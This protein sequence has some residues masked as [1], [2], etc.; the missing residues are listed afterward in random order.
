M[1][2]SKLFK[3][4]SFLLIVT[5][6][7]FLVLWLTQLFQPCYQCDTGFTFSQGGFWTLT[8]AALTDS[9]NPC[10]LA[11][12]LI[13]IE[14]LIL[15]RRSVLKIGLSF[16]GGIYLAYLLIGLG[17]FSGFELIK[18]IQ[19]FHQVIGGLAILVGILN[20]KDYFWYGKFFLM[21]IPTSWRPKMGSFIQRA[22]QPAIAFLTGMIISLFELPCTGGPYI[23]A[24]GLL[25]DESLQLTVLPYLLYYNFLFVLPLLVIILTVYFSYVKIERIEQLRK[26]N[27][28][29]LHLVG[30]IVMLGLGVWLIIQ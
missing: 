20:I 7:I 23:F 21:E 5:A 3:I 26:R 27:I 29:L 12:L 4:I 18:N 9:I 17:L 24:L 15:I 30:G 25:K 28:K 19:F 11:V 1:N 14:G 6:T 16:I 2:K 22:G 13:L 8:L 10:A